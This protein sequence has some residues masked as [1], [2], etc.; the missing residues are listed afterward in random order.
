MMRAP[1]R[2]GELDHLRDVEARDALGHDD[3]QLD[4]VLDRLEHGVADERGR[5]GDDGA[6]DRR[7]VVLDRLRDGVVDRH[8]MD[9]AP[10]AAR[11]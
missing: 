10:A 4:A 11:A 6:V 8:A 2:V 3:D 7:A 9:V 5:H 1:V